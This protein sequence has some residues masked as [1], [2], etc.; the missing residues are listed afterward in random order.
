[1]EKH[2]ALKPHIGLN[3][4]KKYLY[5]TKIITIKLKTLDRWVHHQSIDH[6]TFALNN[7]NY[8]IRSDVLKHLF[9]LRPK[10]L[11]N[12]LLKSIEDPVS[13]VVMVALDLLEKLD[14]KNTAGLVKYALKKGIIS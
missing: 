12:L 2:K 5:R 9:K 1:M 8:I 11:E 6:L 4:I 3:A 10:S 14:V 13:T 7:G